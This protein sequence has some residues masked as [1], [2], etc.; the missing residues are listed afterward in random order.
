MLNRQHS[1]RINKWRRERERVRDGAEAVEHVYVRLRLSM[2]IF[3]SDLKPVTF[4]QTRDTAD[5]AF[6]SVYVSKHTAD[7]CTVLVYHLPLP[8][9]C[10]HNLIV[11]NI[12]TKVRED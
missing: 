10:I 6:P 5:V 3:R 2:N 8:F 11:R 7:V 12:L 1:E 4:R 9:K